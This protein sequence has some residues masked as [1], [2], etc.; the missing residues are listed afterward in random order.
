VPVAGIADFRQ[1]ILFM[2]LLPGNEDSAAVV[3]A[4][5]A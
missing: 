4:D 5:V 3:H 1:P 2:Q